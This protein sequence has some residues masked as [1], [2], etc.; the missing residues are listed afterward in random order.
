M[1]GD[2]V[3]C[4]GALAAGQL[5]SPF[6]NKIKSSG[7]YYLVNDRKKKPTPAVIAFTRWLESLIAEVA[8]SKSSRS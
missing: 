1:M 3:T 4:A 5:V 7:G 8:E 2:E 6:T